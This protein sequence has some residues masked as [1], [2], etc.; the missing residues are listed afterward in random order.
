MQVKK[1]IIWIEAIPQSMV[2][3]IHKSYSNNGVQTEPSRQYLVCKTLNHRWKTTLRV[4]VYD[5]I[6]TRNDP[7][8]REFLWKC[9]AR[10]IEIKELEKVK[11]FLAIEVAYSRK[12]NMWWNFSNKSELL[13]AR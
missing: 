12:G 9:L 4:Y 10:E 5:I 3:E 11:Y 1:H 7:I 13:A 8:G 6:V 2:C